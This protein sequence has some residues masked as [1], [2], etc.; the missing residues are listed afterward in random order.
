MLR[1]SEQI[2]VPLDTWNKP[3][4][5][6]LCVFAI[7]F[8]TQGFFKMNYEAKNKKRVLTFSKSW[9]KCSALPG[10]LPSFVLL[11]PAKNF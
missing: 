2:S 10:N 8:L 7:M 5:L 4:D 1:R 9:T 6:L 11:I 3:N